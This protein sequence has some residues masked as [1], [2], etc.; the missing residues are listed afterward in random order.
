M[1]RYASPSLALGATRTE[2]PGN[3]CADGHCGGSGGV[4]SGGCSRGCA[5]EWRLV[6]LQHG[7]ERDTG[8]R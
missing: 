8:R 4:S 5:C 7:Y 1:H 6:A 3:P 2:G